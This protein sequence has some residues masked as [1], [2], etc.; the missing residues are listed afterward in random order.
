MGH[1]VGFW[2]LG[3]RQKPSDQGGQD[4]QNKKTEEASEIGEARVPSEKGA[5]VPFAQS[6]EHG[7]NDL[8][9]IQP[10]KAEVYGDGQH[11]EPGSVGLP[12]QREFGEVAIDLSQILN[13]FRIFRK[14]RIG[15]QILPGR[16]DTRTEGLPF[17]GTDARADNPLVLHEMEKGYHDQQRSK[18]ENL[19]CPKDEENRLDRRSGMAQ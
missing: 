12:G 19:L 16:R 2:F 4:Q 1:I 6:H 7:L 10:I 11:G 8:S 5:M 14:H 18:P 3:G 13:G 15:L 9:M 17:P